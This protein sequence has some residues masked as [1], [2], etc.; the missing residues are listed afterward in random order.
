ML[1]T[2]GFLKAAAAAALVAGG[3]YGGATLSGSDNPSVPAAAERDV[4]TTERTTTT[5]RPTTTVA[6]TTTVP[7]TT[8]VPPTTTTVPPT[9]TPSYESGPPWW[10]D[11]QCTQDLLCGYDG[12]TEPTTTS[13]P[14][15]CRPSTITSCDPDEPMELPVIGCDYL[16]RDIV[17]NV[18]CAG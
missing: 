1:T 16:E 8:T 14:R 4:P 17:G 11:A 12:C 18:R 5:R 15:T 7:T 10:C 13:T 2:G 6:P 3:W 9:T